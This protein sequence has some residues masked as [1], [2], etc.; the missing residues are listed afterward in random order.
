M[1]NP[2]P[3]STTVAR[4]TPAV[5]A[6]A[7]DYSAYFHMFAPLFQQQ[8][9]QYNNAHQTQL[10]SSFQSS[11]AGLQEQ[12]AAE[13][14]EKKKAAA[15]ASAAAAAT[16]AAEAE[17]AEDAAWEPPAAVEEEPTEPLPVINQFSPENRAKVD[18]IE[19]EWRWGSV[20][21]FMEQFLPLFP[22][23]TYF[24]PELLMQAFLC[25]HCSIHAH[26]FTACSCPHPACKHFAN[27]MCQ[28]MLLLNPIPP[29][30]KKLPKNQLN[31][32]NYLPLVQGLIEKFYFMPNQD[33]V[34]DQVQEIMEMFMVDD[35][36][37]KARERDE[38]E[39]KEQ[40][41]R[42]IESK[43]A[44]AKEA[45]QD[46]KPADVVKQEA[47]VKTESEPMQTDEKEEKSYAKPAETAAAPAETVKEETKE[48]DAV[49][50]ESEDQPMT[51]AA[52][53]A[54][55]EA[56]KSSLKFTI[57]IRPPGSLLLSVHLHKLP[58]MA[59]LYLMHMLCDYIAEQLP[60]IRQAG[61]DSMKL[62]AA[63]NKEPT[64]APVQSA[65]EVSDRSLPHNPFHSLGLSVPHGT[66]DN[67]AAYWVFTH[68]ETGRIHLYRDERTG[69]KD[70]WSIQY[71]RRGSRRPAR[72]ALKHGNEIEGL[73]ETEQDREDREQ[74]EQEEEARE[75]E[76][77]AEEGVDDELEPID[78]DHADPT[79]KFTLLNSDLQ[80]VQDFVSIG[81]MSWTKPSSL[82]FLQ[83]VQNEVLPSAILLQKKLERLSRREKTAA[84]ANARIAAYHFT[85]E[86]QYRSDRSQRARKSVNYSEMNG[87]DKDL[88]GGGDD[89][90][91]DKDSKSSAAIPS[92]LARG[93]RSRP[94]PGYVPPEEGAT[95]P[96]GAAVTD[97]V[98]APP[99][100]KKAKKE[101]KPKAPKA[102][103]VA[104]P[105]AAPLTPMVAASVPHLTS[106]NAHAMN[107]MQQQ[108]IQQM[109]MMQMM[110][111]YGGYGAAPAV[112][113][114][115]A[116]TAVAQ[117]TPIVS[118][119]QMSPQPSPTAPA[120]V[121]A[122]VAAT[123]PEPAVAAAVATPAP[124]PVTTTP[125]DTSATAAPATAA[126]SLQH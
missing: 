114:V 71:R 22:R 116:P 17:A 13:A 115:A 28:L 5:V 91:D 113:T 7:P 46:E 30:C 70:E 110:H 36:E 97:D 48:Q 2:I 42:D 75:D 103:K 99:P 24:K 101:P 107:L 29:G 86:T 60:E 59:K 40:E 52:E 39:A 49:K 31:V 50:Q 100:A 92:S 93:T 69:A 96:A 15:A 68:E 118:T 126:P 94:A 43:I 108:Y 67:G 12:Q 109:Q 80:G 51:D 122:A 83:R 10:F 26:A 85:G 78:A 1:S 38:L 53:P 120:V 3:A 20:C 102:P 64:P 77:M 19:S 84:A 32:N 58:G 45:A 11:F 47:T 57:P 121:A 25:Q 62:L 124:S 23:H 119:P 106:A 21:L 81:F 125:M 34:R 79:F 35:Q 73:D 87:A 76:E 74:R 14:R 33:A 8:R 117:S 6:S 37:R 98:V 123:V 27:L 66:D 65:D 55:P 54:A 104:A 82:E 56:K 16:A 61:E 9:L 95:V 18:A 111:L 44:A 112:A 89:D 88:D 41:L 72:E 90:E 105:A 4:A 63:G